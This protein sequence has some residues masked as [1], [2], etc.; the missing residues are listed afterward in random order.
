MIVKNM[1]LNNPTQNTIQ[2]DAEGHVL[3]SDCLKEAFIKT[4][5][6]GLY[7]DVEHMWKEFKKNAE[8]VIKSSA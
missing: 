6:R 4:V 7:W 5:E 2:I 3:F 1:I 8:A